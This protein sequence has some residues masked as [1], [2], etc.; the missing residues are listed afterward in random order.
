MYEKSELT[1]WS[2]FAPR[3]T[4][5]AGAP[6]ATQYFRIK[7]TSWSSDSSSGNEALR[8]GEQAKA[9]MLTYEFTTGFAEHVPQWMWVDSGVEVDVYD[10]FGRVCAFVGEV[11][12]CTLNRNTGYWET[13]GTQGLRRLVHVDGATPGQTDVNCIVYPTV[14]DDYTTSGP[15]LDADHTGVASTDTIP[16]G[17]AWI[18]YRQ[19]NR[20][21]GTQGY[22]SQNTLTD[23]HWIFTD[24]ECP[25]QPAT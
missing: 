5:S 10:M 16:E 2:R 20:L 14:V 21:F 25:E 3:S 8:P 17:K 24:W 12:Q 15:T 19:G 23:G 1:N 7:G 11:I 18:E 22:S 13:V 6:P 4:G 9:Y